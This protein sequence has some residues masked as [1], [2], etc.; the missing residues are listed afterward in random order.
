LAKIDLVGKT[1]NR[2]TSE[3]KIYFSTLILQLLMNRNRNALPDREGR[4]ITTF[5]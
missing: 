4:E 3:V 1:K 2:T 5:L